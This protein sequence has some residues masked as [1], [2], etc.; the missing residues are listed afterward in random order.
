MIR[1]RYNKVDSGLLM[2]NG[3]LAVNDMVNVTLNPITMTMTIANSRN[4]VVRSGTSKTLA[5]LK[6]L[7]KSAL[8]DLGVVFTDEIRPRKVKH[9]EVS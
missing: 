7:A 4:E 6:M 8:K 9:E 3:I 2:S 1:V 5:G